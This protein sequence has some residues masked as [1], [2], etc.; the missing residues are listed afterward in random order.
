MVSPAATPVAVL[1]VEVMVT[2]LLPLAGLALAGDRPDGVAPAVGLNDD[3]SNS[4]DR[5]G[6]TSN[7][8]LLVKRVFRIASDSFLII[9]VFNFFDLQ[10]K[11]WTTKSVFII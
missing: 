5:N 11:V 4:I 3:S 1:T 7:R 2:V 6:M 10:A 9:I 8:V